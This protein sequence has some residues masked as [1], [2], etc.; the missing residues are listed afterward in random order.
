MPFSAPGDT[1]GP[2]LPSEL[3]TPAGDDRQAGATGTPTPPPAPSV[4][5]APM[6]PPTPMPPSAPSAP[7]D[8]AAPEAPP[9]PATPAFG[10]SGF[11]IDNGS[12][13][14]TETEPKPEPVD[15]SKAAFNTDPE[16]DRS[17][18]PGG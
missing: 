18:R 7:S 9:A 15:W 5:P 12:D 8:P 16:S 10:A 2:W 11:R 4:P 17:Y 1:R 14:E 3:R 13:L 6:A